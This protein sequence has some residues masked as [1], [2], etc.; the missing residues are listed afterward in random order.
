M[1]HRD[2]WQ[3]LSLSLL[4][5]NIPWEWFFTPHNEH[6]I[7]STKLLVWFL[8]EFHSWN[9]SHHLFLNFLLFTSLLFT[10]WRVCLAPLPSQMRWLLLL[11]FIP[12]LSTLN[13]ENHLW[14]F[15]TSIHSYLLL[16]ALACLFSRP[17]RSF[18]SF[19]FACICL[20]FASFCFSAAQAASVV[21]AFCFI[22]ESFSSSERSTRRFRLL[23]SCLVLIGLVVLFSSSVFRSSLTPSHALSLPTEPR[24]WMFFLNTVSL[25][26]GVETYSLA[27][28]L[29]CFLLCLS[30]LF[31]ALTSARSFDW[32]TNRSAALMSIALLSSIAAIAAGRG[33]QEEIEIWSKGS[34]YYEIASL[35]VPLSVSMLLSRAQNLV[36]NLLLVL[37]SLTAGIAHFNNYSFSLYYWTA[38]QKRNGRD[39]AR[40]FLLH[41][42][43]LE[44]SSIWGMGTE[45]ELL[46]SQKLK[47]SYLQQ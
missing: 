11:S 43:S 15:Q 38:E 13:W 34:R 19:L 28:G 37:I 33:T 29:L 45:Q 10:T 47:L 6:Y 3:L 40:E 9:V 41:E 39:C 32:K 17:G 22:C 2:E 30:A 35:L 36:R 14:A 31:L 24:F 20:L 23:T 26:F 12:P 25:G 16:I 42:S 7:L 4:Q 46:R 5:T 18:S 27:L 1:P 44:C 21:L 8:Y